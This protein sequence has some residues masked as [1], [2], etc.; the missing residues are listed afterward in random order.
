MTTRN[1]DSLAVLL[2][3]AYNN[4]SYFGPWAFRTMGGAGG[5]TVFTALTTGTHGGDFRALPIADSV[6]AMHLVT[7]GGK[8]Y[9]IEPET[10]PTTVRMTDDTK[11]RALY[12]T[13]RYGGPG[14]FEIRR[15]DDLFNAVLMSAGRFGIVYSVGVKHGLGL[16]H[17]EGRTWRGWHHHVTLVTTAQAFLTL[18]RLHPKAPT[19]A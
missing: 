19:P 1:P 12:G 5:Q 6:L 14:N 10:S 17:F 13:P 4:T 18:R 3:H 15:S 8:H 9:W 7:D 2:Q 16:D 11:L